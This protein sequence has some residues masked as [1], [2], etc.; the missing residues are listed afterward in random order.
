MK[1]R[2]TIIVAALLSPLVIA[3]N[4][5]AQDAADHDAEV[6]VLE[7]QIAVLEAQIETVE[8]RIQIL[9]TEFAAVE[10]QIRQLQDQTQLHMQ[11]L[12]DLTQAMRQMVQMTRR[13]QAELMAK[14]RMIVV[15]RARQDGVLDSAVDTEPA[16]A[17]CFADVAQRAGIDDR[18][19]GNAAAWLDYDNDGDLDLYFVNDPGSG[20][21]YRNNSDGTFEPVSSGLN[22]NGNCIAPADY[23]RDG[24]VDVAL[25]GAGNVALYRNGRNGT[26]EDMTAI[27][28]INVGNSQMLLWGDYNQDGYPDL[29]IAGSAR[30]LY[31]NNR[32]GTFTDVTSIVPAIATAACSA[33]WADYN[34]DGYDDLVIAEHGGTMRLFR[35][36]PLMR[37][38]EDVSAVAGISLPT[39]SH[40]LVIGDYDRNGYPDVY[41]FGGGSDNYLFRNR[42]DGTF[43]EVA[44]A[45]GV[46]DT[47][48]RGHNDAV[49][50]DFDRD[51]D[52]DLFANGGRYGSNNFFR[53][54]G[55]GTFEDITARTGLANTDDTHALAVGDF[56]GDGYPDIYEVNF[57]GYGSSANRLFRNT[58]F[59]LSPVMPAGAD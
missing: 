50:L 55:N 33:I 8:A 2:L 3:G 16:V 13:L 5:L 25:G 4:A 19:S 51:G 48:G 36:N 9:E 45:A 12:K 1:M 57:T 53:N 22:G 6:A 11:R 38:F 21:F 40:R 10:T 59:G 37:T 23:D 52:L 58:G 26:F 28:G 20:G 32:D 30:R 42:G 31:R 56:D 49:F 47:A 39:G 35:Y 34:R 27:A 24:Y 18:G 43:E 29:Y 54:N 7:D 15:M 14:R 46:R 17:S 41:A 44:L